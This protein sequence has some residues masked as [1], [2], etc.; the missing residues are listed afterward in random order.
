MSESSGNTR[1]IPVPDERSQGYWDAAAEHVLAIARCSRCATFVMPPDIVC[2]HCHSTE[3]DF[4]FVPVSGR[5]VV[6][7]WTV[8]HQS[9]VPGFDD[10]VPFVLV[11]VEL[12]EQADLRTIG[13]LLA[14]PEVLDG[15]DA[16]LAIGARVV[17]AF[18]DL[19]PGISVPAFELETEEA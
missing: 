15:P 11:D 18:E 9:F 19:A 10:L 12:E 6:R 4:T 7:S 17:V 8:M 14:G 5:G 16:P 1:P 3:P 13:R 2:S